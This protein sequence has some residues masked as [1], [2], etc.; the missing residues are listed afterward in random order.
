M[1]EYGILCI[2]DDEGSWLDIS[3]SGEQIWFSISEKGDDIDTCKI[4][5]LTLEQVKRLRD[6]L[7]EIINEKSK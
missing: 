1:K 4:M 6:H 7:T 3:F 2:K 5:W